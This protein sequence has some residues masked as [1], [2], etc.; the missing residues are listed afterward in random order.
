MQPPDPS[1]PPDE[2]FSP[3]IRLIGLSAALLIGTV[4]C[5]LIALPFLG[6]LTW[7]LTLGV[8]FSPVQARLEKTLRRPGLAALITVFA[9]ILIVGTPAMLI[10]N[11][12]VQGA[13]SGA[14]LIQSQLANGGLE[15]PPFIAQIQAQVDLPGLISRFSN[16]LSVAGASFVRGSF[17]QI[18]DVV[19]TFYMLFYFLR[20]RHAALRG[21][22]EV[23]PLGEGEATQLFRRIADTV[24][25]LVYGTLMVA[26]LQGALAG[27]MFWILG[28]PA[29]LFWGVVMSILAIMP[30]LGTFVIWIPQAIYL[31]LTGEEVKAAILALWGAL[32]V[33]E[34][35]NVVRPILVGNRLKLPTLP[36]FIAIIGGLMVF[37]MPGFILGPLVMTISLFLL[38]AIRRPAAR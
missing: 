32:V 7:A 5:C 25:A 29:P 17:K 12:L 13:I 34:I 31:A 11:W 19:L 14:A 30:V 10:I 8:V 21:I 6:A 2:R 35:D 9:A 23:L 20:D 16:S 36:T 37:G 38:S 26:A 28:L 3:Q 27:L 24:Q 18:V 15:L 4:L 33:G 1:P 22:R